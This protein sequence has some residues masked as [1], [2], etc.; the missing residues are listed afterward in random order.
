MEKYLVEISIQ[1]EGSLT[2][3]GQG[4]RVGL[5]LDKLEVEAKSAEEARRIA[6]KLYNLI[7]TIKN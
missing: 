6:S 2:A 3:K 1:S 7:F 4:Q 5:I